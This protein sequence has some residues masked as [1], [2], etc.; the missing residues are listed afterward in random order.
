M[1]KTAKL[2]FFDIYFISISSRAPFKNSES[3]PGT[4][5]RKLLRQKK[6]I[7]FATYRSPA[8]L[9]PMIFLFASHPAHTHANWALSDVTILISRHCLII[10]NTH[11]YSG[12]ITSSTSAGTL[13]M[14]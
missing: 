7:D 8:S 11:N 9:F 5:F 13:K 6:Q 12:A 4:K 2:E 3:A 10:E 14:K 1:R